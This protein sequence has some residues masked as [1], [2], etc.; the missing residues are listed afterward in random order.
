ME[1]CA[2]HGLFCQQQRT[3]FE[4][5]D[6]GLAKCGAAFAGVEL[7]G[8]DQLLLRRTGQRDDHLRAARA[9]RSASSAKSVDMAA[10]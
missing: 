2:L 3:S 10:P 6:E 7:R 5:G 4:F 9:D 1:G 8:L